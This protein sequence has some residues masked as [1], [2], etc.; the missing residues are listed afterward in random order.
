[1]DCMLIHLLSCSSSRVCC[2]PT[3]SSRFKK[4]TST[5]E[6]FLQL[7][8]QVH[9][10]RVINLA[11]VLGLFDPGSRGWFDFSLEEMA[12]RLVGRSGMGI[13]GGE[14][15]SKAEL[16]MNIYQVIA[17]LRSIL[18]TTMRFGHCGS[19]VRYL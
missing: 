8:P 2:P 7:R 5:L 12:S 6:E 19:Y 16:V 18:S 3:A 13:P 9:Y 17:S 15:G 14:W 10:G 1:M 4:N 11:T